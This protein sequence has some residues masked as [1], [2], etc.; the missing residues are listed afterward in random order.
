MNDGM[1]CCR[2]GVFVL[3][4]RRQSVHAKLVTVHHMDL[5][6]V[7]ALAMLP[8]HHAVLGCQP[9]WEARSFMINIFFFPTLMHC[10]TIGR[11]HC[12][13][14]GDSHVGCFKNI[15]TLHQII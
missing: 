14:A 3:S 4:Y 6:G 15:A 7:H 2:L 5:G 13:L 1:W 12:N 10:E 8:T 11:N 9:P